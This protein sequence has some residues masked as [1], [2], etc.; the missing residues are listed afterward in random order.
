[1]QVLPAKPR[2][3]PPPAATYADDPVNVTLQVRGTNLRGNG[4]GAL[5]GLAGAV[6]GAHVA[7]EEEL[8]AETAGRDGRGLPRGNRE[9]AADVLNDLDAGTRRDASAIATGS[10]HVN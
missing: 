8:A 5:A 7:G 10:Q 4:G 1:M 3:I 2:L 6:L 9:E